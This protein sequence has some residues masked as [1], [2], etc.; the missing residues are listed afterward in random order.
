MDHLDALLKLAKEHPFLAS[1][2]FL[3]VV[4]ELI[5][6]ASLLVDLLILLVRGL[7]SALHLFAGKF[8]TLWQEC[9]HWDPLSERDDTRRNSHDVSAPRALEAPQSSGRSQV[10]A[11]SI[12]VD[13]RSPER[14]QR[15]GAE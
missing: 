1:G 8:R 6:R 2:V 7:K 15:A 12:S 13:G 5:H 10:A 3:L 14:E 9:T 4:I 11:L